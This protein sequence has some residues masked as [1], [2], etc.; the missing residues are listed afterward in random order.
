MVPPAAN[1]QQEVFWNG[2]TKDL[3]PQLL[4]TLKLVGTALVAGLALG[5]AAG[6]LMSRLAPGWARRGV[7]GA[8]TALICLPDLLIATALDL[9]LIFAFQARGV[10]LTANDL[11]VYQSFIAPALGLTLLVVPT[12]MIISGSLVVEY[13]TEVNGLGRALMVSLSPFYL[14][15]RSSYAAILIL[16]P[17]LLVS[18]LAAAASEAG[19]RW[20]DPRMA[21]GQHA[22]E[23]RNVRGFHP[24]EAAMALARLPRDVWVAPRDLG[25]WA[26]T[27]PAAAAEWCR[28]IRARLRGTGRALRQPMLLA[29]TLLVL[30]LV[31]VALFPGHIAQ[32][33]PNQ[34]FRA[35]QD[36]AGVVHA[37]PF[38][39]GPDHWLGTYPLGHDLASRLIYG[40]RYALLFAALAVPARWH[41]RGCLAWLHP[42]GNRLWRCSPRPLSKALWRWAPAPA[43]SW[44]A[45]FC[46]RWGRG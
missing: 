8:T 11:R 9:G 6:W 37:P 40:T 31:L 20:L 38:L 46:H 7:F 36:A 23:Q 27:R 43:V 17:L 14:G 34:V 22:A 32:Y 26:A 44:C 45:M 4:V 10:F 3:F 33:P 5:S 35:Y 24:K 30:G 25:V 12:G 21:E 39:P 15:Y 29:G 1:W 16:L 28:G 13:M 41:C 42:Y 2:V 18:A 19:L